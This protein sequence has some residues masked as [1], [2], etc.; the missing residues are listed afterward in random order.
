MTEQDR[1]QVF[2]APSGNARTFPNLAAHAHQG[3]DVGQGDEVDETAE[4]A[5]VAHG[6]GVLAE[7]VAGHEVGD[8][9]QAHVVEAAE[10]TVLER[11]C[12]WRAGRWDTGEWTCGGLL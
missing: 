9:A 6:L 7:G 8:D 5:G 2:A 12:S 11:H 1:Q 3:C 10:Q 4:E